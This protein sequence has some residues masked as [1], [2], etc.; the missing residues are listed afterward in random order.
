[1]A[2][3]K[4]EEEHENHERWLVSYA[5]FI[6]LLF[7]F[8]TVLYA[9]SQRDVEKEKKFERSIRESFVTFADLGEFFRFYDFGGS[10]GGRSVVPP[11]NNTY[12]TMGKPGESEEDTGEHPGSGAATLSKETLDELLKKQISEQDQQA[13]DM[14]FRHDTVGARVTMAASSL[15]KSGSAK[16][17]PTAFEFLDKLGQVLKASSHKI[18]VEGHTDDVPIQS[19]QFPSNWDLAAARA[20]TMARFLIEWHKIAPSRLVVVSY[21]DQRPLEP[22]KTD[23]ARAKNRRIELLISE[24]VGTF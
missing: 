19:D 8:F 17:Q 14:S 2:K 24:K 5:D 13:L 6:T 12:E 18:I 23:A 9:T 3:K 1:M 21:G 22:N 20:S 16:L 4:H 10:S 15:F 11:M 7:A